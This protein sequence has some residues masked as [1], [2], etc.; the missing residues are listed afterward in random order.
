MT[1]CENGQ[2]VNTR[3]AALRFVVM[4]GVVSLFSDM[5][6]EGARAV[7]GPYLGLLGA[8]AVVVGAVSGAGELLGYGLRLLS[9]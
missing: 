8:S 6:Y 2:L 3:S 9:G 7:T 5:T 4:L 1:V